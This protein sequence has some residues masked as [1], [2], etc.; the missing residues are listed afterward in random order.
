MS[1]V[2]FITGTSRGLGRAFAKSALERGDKVAA[3]ARNAAA[4]D[5]LVTKYGEGAVLPLA[6]DVTDK[7]AVTA[8]V[9]AAHEKFGRLDVV[10]NNAGYGLFGMVEEI[11]EQQLR[12]Q[13]ET[14]LFGAFWVSQ[15]VLPILRAQ[16]S[17]HIVQISSVGG[18]IAF[19]TLGAYHASK[20]ALEGFSE[21]LAGEVA[22][23][24]IKVTI[25]EPGGFSTDWGGSSSTQAEPNPAYDQVREAVAARF[26]EA[27]Y[28]ES[29]DA[30]AALLWIVDAENPPLRV[31]F[32]TEPIEIIEPVYAQ[33]LRTWADWE[34]VSRIAQG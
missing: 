20:W 25:V 32:G 31:L 21:A 9:A 34:H 14:N 12:D 7:A 6:L 27:R 30:G 2:W 11:T 28:A 1:K 22:G 13:M 15:A 24:G 4:L 16:G 17:G 10:V 26:G 8:A 29:A 19:P 5:D 33:R 18:V 3:T 23:Q